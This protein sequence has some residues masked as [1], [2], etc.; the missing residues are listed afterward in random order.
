MIGDNFKAA[1]EVAIR[2]IVTVIVHETIDDTFMAGN[3]VQK[4]G[5]KTPIPSM[6]EGGPVDIV[7]QGHLDATLIRNEEKLANSA[8]FMDALARQFV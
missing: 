1:V 2:R 8:R 7:E 4:E 5:I 3:N 6:V